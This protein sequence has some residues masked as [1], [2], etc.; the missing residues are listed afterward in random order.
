MLAASA[1][2]QSLGERQLHSLG[3][4]GLQQHPQLNHQQQ[5]PQLGTFSFA[6]RES[7]STTSLS[8]APGSS[9]HGNPDGQGM[10]AQN[11]LQS[12]QLMQQQQQLMQQQ[13]HGRLPLAVD[14]GPRA[15]NNSSSASPDVPMHDT[16]ALED[17][18]AEARALLEQRARGPAG[19]GSGGAVSGLGA[20][21]T[22]G[23]E[24]ELQL[25]QHQQQRRESQVAY[26]DGSG[27]ARVSGGDGGGGVAFGAVARHASLGSTVDNAAATRAGER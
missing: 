14:A 1:A 11:L 15:L 8:T 13:Q 2:L 6:P 17:A 9:L 21:A 3:V 10:A 27:V 20:L 24:R 5:Q 18:L 23:S 16:S 25:L 22:A 7:Q 26:A 12:L 4:T 19:G